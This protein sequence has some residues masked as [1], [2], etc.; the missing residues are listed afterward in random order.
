MNGA[1]LSV[2]DIPCERSFGNFVNWSHVMSKLTDLWCH[3][4]AIMMPLL[5]TEALAGYASFK[6]SRNMTMTPGTRIPDVIVPMIDIV[7]EW[8]SDSWLFLGQR[9]LYETWTRPRWIGS[10]ESTFIFS[11]STFGWYAEDEA[12]DKLCWTQCL[13]Q[14][15]KEDKA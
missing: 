6:R 5:I 8:I 15:A 4:D 2:F 9:L 10:L 1:K 13:D 7:H 14:F 11:F 3:Y 12:K